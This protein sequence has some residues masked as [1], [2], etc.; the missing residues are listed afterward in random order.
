MTTSPRSVCTWRWVRDG[1]SGGR[2]P[3]GVVDEGEVGRSGVDAVEG[4]VGVLLGD[5]QA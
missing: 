5:V 4:L 3:V 1:G 2:Q